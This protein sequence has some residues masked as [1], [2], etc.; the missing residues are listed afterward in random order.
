MAVENRMIEPFA[1]GQTK[2]LENGLRVIS[3]GLSSY[4]YDL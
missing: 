2:K 1:D 4:G 3:Y